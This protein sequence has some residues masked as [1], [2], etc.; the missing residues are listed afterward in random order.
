M[1]KQ[2]RD[3]KTE[4]NRDET[5]VRKEPGE[6]SVKLKVRW[7]RKHYLEMYSKC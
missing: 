3:I 6:E 7:T 1:R 4:N 5:I 2:I